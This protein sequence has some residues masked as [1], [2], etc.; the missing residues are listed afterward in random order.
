M[1]S[2]SFAFSLC[3]GLVPHWQNFNQ[4]RMCRQKHV[5]QLSPN[6][7]ETSWFVC[8]FFQKLVMDV[9]PKNREG[10]V[11]RCCLVS[12]QVMFVFVWQ[13][14]GGSCLFTKL[15]NPS[16]TEDYFQYR[17]IC[18]I[19]SRLHCWSFIP[20]NVK[21]NVKNAYLKPKLTSSNCVFCPPTSQNTKTLHLLS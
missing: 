6:I 10:D 9:C 2:D 11:F 14:A 16:W 15:S 4:T 3:R 1:G 17:L 21:K 7:L 5:L 18:Q 13:T 19:F 12:P 20:W 8:L